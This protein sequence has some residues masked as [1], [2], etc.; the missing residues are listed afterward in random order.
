MKTQIHSLEKECTISMLERIFMERTSCILIEDNV[1]EFLDET[2]KQMSKG[3]VCCKCPN[4]CDKTGKCALA[5][6]NLLVDIKMFVEAYKKHNNL[7]QE[8]E[9]QKQDDNQEGGKE[10]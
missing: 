2:E 9:N 7:I 10:V 1:L 5:M 4:P 8:E 6:K 3:L